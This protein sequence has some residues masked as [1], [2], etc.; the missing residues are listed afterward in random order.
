MVYT[1]AN[2]GNEHTAKAVLLAA[3]IS[4]KQSVELCRYLRGMPL[5]KALRVLEDVIRK[6]HPIPYRR[7]NDNVGH[8]RGIAAGRYPVK[9]SQYFLALLKSVK[10]NAAVKGLK[11]EKLVII[12]L[13]ANRA[14]RP[15]HAGRKR[16]T[17][18]KRTHV[19]VL[20]AEQDP[21][22][23]RAKRAGTAGS[24]ASNTSQKT[25]KGANPNPS[26]AAGDDGSITQQPSK[27]QKTNTKK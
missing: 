11:E 15:M 5:A 20:V 6:V 19:E 9:A 13:L 7:Y 8:K 3:P 1:Y 17:V 18:M 25:M 22:A 24:Q 2:K 26:P 21:V 14:S 27:L 4:T 10:A 23:Q 16:G 12:H